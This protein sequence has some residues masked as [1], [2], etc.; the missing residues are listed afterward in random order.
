MRVFSK[1][2]ALYFIFSQLL[3][4]R[5]QRFNHAMVRSTIH[6]SGQSLKLC[7]RAATMDNFDIKPRQKFIAIGN[8][9]SKHP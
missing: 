7:G 8:H 6:R 9:A 3:A 5:R 1:A 4:N 2:E